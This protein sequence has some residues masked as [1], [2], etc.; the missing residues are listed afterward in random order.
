MKNKLISSFLV[1][2]IG[3][4][5]QSQISLT[6]TTGTTTGS[7]TNISAA[8]AAINAGTHT[9][10][11]VINI[12]S[13]ITA[14]PFLPT[15]LRESGFGAASYNDVLIRPVGNRNVTGAF[16]LNSNRGMIE[17][18]GAKNVTIDGDDPATA[19]T[20]NLA[21]T[22]NP[23]SSNLTAAI[24]IGSFSTAAFAE[25]IIVRNCVINGPRTTTSS[26]TLNCG[27][28]V[29]NATLASLVTQGLSCKNIDILNNEIYRSHVGIFIVGPSTS[30]NEFSNIRIA[31]NIIGTSTTSSNQL[32]RA[33]IVM[34]G[35]ASSSAATAS[36]IVS[37][38]ISVGFAGATHTDE[39]IGID[40]QL[41]SAGTVISHNEITDI[42]NGNAAAL[43][44]AGIRVNGILNSGISIFNNIIKD[45]VGIRRLPALGGIANY[46]VYIGTGVT[47]LSF[48][49][50]T[51]GLITQNLGAL[52]TARNSSLYIANTS[53]FSLFRN[54]ILVNNN[55]SPNATVVSQNGTIA[56]TYPT[57][58]AMDRNCYF[59]PGGSSFSNSEASLTSWQLMNNR[60][61]TSFLENPP[62]VSLNN[63]RIATGGVTR[64]ES[65][66]LLSTLSND[67]D[68]NPRPGPVGSVNGG[69]TIRDIGAHEVD[70]KSYI[71]STISAI[72]IPNDIA[73]F[74][75]PRTITAVVSGGNAVETV[76]LNYRIGP[77]P[78]T[79][80]IMT[81]SSTLFSG[82]IPA[83]LPQNARVTFRIFTNNA[84]LDTVSSNFYSYNNISADSAMFPTVTLDPQ[85]ICSN[86]PVTMTYA[87]PPDPTGV[88]APP[89][90][91]DALNLS[92]L[93]TVTIAGMTNNTSIGSL[94]G[95]IGTATGTQ[96]AYS[97]FR[98]MATPKVTL[99]YAYPLTMTSVSNGLS[100][101]FFAAYV[102]WNGD[103]DFNDANE[104]VFN[105]I[106]ARTQ[107]PRTEIGQL[108]VVPSA[109]PGIT[110]VRVIVSNSPITGPFS[111]IST[112]EVEDY[113]IEIRR[114]PS[115]EWFVGPTSLG[116][117]NPTTYTVPTAPASFSLKITDSATCF[118]TS[119]TLATV[120][121]SAPALTVSISGSP[122]VCA[123][124]I[125]G[126]V[127]NVSGGC[128]PYTYAWSTGASTRSIN[129]TVV[130]AATIPYSVTVT[131]RNS[132]PGV[133]NFVIT[134]VNPTITALDT[135]VCNRGSVDLTA[136]VANASGD[137]AA[138]YNSFLDPSFS[139]LKLGRPFKTPVLDVT[140]T[141]FVAAYRATTNFIG[142]IN[143]TGFTTSSLIQPHT[144]FVFNTSE[145]IVI[146]SV[147]LYMAG[148][149]AEVNIALLDRFGSIIAQTGK[150]KVV[151]GASALVPS[152]VPLFFSIPTP[153]VGYRLAI[154]DT[155]G[156]T[157]L[158]RNTGVVYPISAG[159]PMVITGGY[160]SQ[161]PTGTTE[162]NCF[163]N[164]IINRNVCVGTKVPV[165]VKVTTPRVP[166][167][168]K[169]IQSVQVCPGSSATISIATDSFGD[170][171][172][173]FVNRRKVSL[174]FVSNFFGKNLPISSVLNR[175]SARSTVTIP[176]VR[177]RDTGLYF[178]RVIPT[179]VCTRDTFS[180]EIRLSYY[181]EVVFTD[182]LKTENVCL[183]RGKQ[184]SVKT[185]FGSEYNWYRNGALVKNDTPSV[186]GARSYY[187]IDSAVY[188]DSG[189][190][191]VIA[192]HP[193]SC[194]PTISN[195]DT[196]NVFVRDT[197]GITLDPID[198]VICVG[199]KYT[200]RSRASNFTDL[201]WYK[202]GSPIFGANQDTLVLFRPLLADSGRYQLK[203][204]SYPG[205]PDSFSKKASIK[206]NR[207][208][209]ING[210]YPDLKFCEN[211]KL[212]L[213]SNYEMSPGITWYKNNVATTNILD[214]LVIPFASLSDAG[215]YYYVAQPFDKCP[216][217]S[218]DT[219][220]V[221]V[222]AKPGILNTTVPNSAMCS[223]V[224]LTKAFSTTNANFYQWYKN[225][226]PL[227]SE[228][229]SIFS[230]ESVS[231]NDTGFYNL[232]VISD[233]ICPEAISPSFRVTV[234][235]R[236]VITKHPEGDTLC[237]GDNITLS[238]S[239]QNSSGFQ[240][241]KNGVF[242]TN[243]TNPTL[244]LTNISGVNIG[245]Y[246]AIV[247]GIAPCPDLET[248]TAS[249]D[250]RSGASN[251]YL[252]TASSYSLRE[253][254]RDEDGW[255]YYV[256]PS[257]PNKF[258]FG[259][260]K[261]GNTT[262]VGKA[263][264][265]L[266]PSVF[267]HIAN[268]INQYSGSIL[269]SRYWN[270][271]VESGSF[272]EPVDVKF[273]YDQNELTSLN[274]RR[275]EIKRVQ[276]SD[277]I[278]EDE[279]ERWFKTDSTEMTPDR[280]AQIYGSY[281]GFKFL[282]LKDYE[283]DEENGVKYIIF[284]DVTNIG[285]G[286]AFY[287]FNGKTKSIG[288]VLNQNGAL[289]SAIYPNPNAGQFE[290]Q[291]YVQKIAP[292]VAEVY[293]S[294][295][296]K[297]YSEQI[298]VS[299]NEMKISMTLPEMAS[300]IYQL[301]LT[302]GEHSTSLKFRIDK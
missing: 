194:L 149:N 50:N 277:V 274:S 278:F 28:V 78:W 7:Y 151:L 232:R 9:G 91:L 271:A 241:K 153:G 127:A 138:W 251:A 192:K 135:F 296:Q 267:Q 288:A 253:Q 263:D 164:I 93:G 65:N 46:G 222:F 18:F 22:V 175:D 189:F 294:L 290:L 122:S 262:L 59:Y 190:Y 248:D 289:S 128:P 92:D 99:G 83:A 213:N 169:D 237:A 55:V 198:T 44:L 103:G 299:K 226:V 301:M 117:A 70:G 81:G 275:D 134:P 236:A 111:T 158:T 14:E 229:D 56:A 243:K 57:G 108:Y 156:I 5:V 143:P 179:K 238:V 142:R 170:A 144:G 203:A 265:V 10:S 195:I 133:A 17:L 16:G 252:A 264:V 47:G 155:G 171:F 146:R 234:Q 202:D 15:S 219:F 75:G 225:G 184:L 106:Q 41:N 82:T 230:I 191:Y 273:Y 281:F 206:I 27:I 42:I 84:L 269:M 74:S 113:T 38:K 61:L 270:Y 239:A 246:T 276:G 302:Q 220:K 227:Q 284:R 197:P 176:S 131:D 30:G 279:T 145:P 286:T 98:N 100:R 256:D 233:P 118:R 23:A 147:D 250:I 257:Q 231:F 32:G 199:T 162:Y 285:G 19:G 110:N 90:V 218:S 255:T 196:V 43:Q 188:Q 54:N 115:I 215:D 80:I 48:F 283:K 137:S 96:G 193:F 282:Q 2:L 37:N 165:E 116:T 260:N 139:F 88:T 261:K 114:H 21:F 183:K 69:G 217:V 35:V 242:E 94:T 268:D 76:N 126:M 150:V 205:C 95:S 73:C 13:D 187:E 200:I 212:R 166:A 228:I 24:R 8:F 66:A 102:D 72:T 49:H 85:Q 45:V 152:R 160:N 272:D 63:L 87:Y 52:T 280:I 300:G 89:T 161:N 31:N 104:A 112:G 25:S 62:F 29:S 136:T 178:V 221:R 119:A 86:T 34:S 40:I 235:Q 214:T 186:L 157:T 291:C 140:T 266:R 180:R 292:M 177:D 298:K 159:Q 201:Q 173:W 120:T 244:P 224:K 26:I 249:I 33:G 67:I 293:N 20:R 64:V 247:R 121:A 3:F 174:S 216:S 124:T 53:S 148:A 254:C 129:V 141:F 71:P 172:D 105:T 79:N 123:N 109:R 295:G 39:S 12:T 297:V 182:S 101:D 223:G 168:T 185:N 204:S 107:G 210:F 51:V 36:T 240:W 208:P 258:L 181:P 11:I 97:N 209:L 259:V 4:E 6:A 1:L 167:I 211:T 154:I 130:G 245:K 60:D 125:A 77:G 68:L 163:Y 207:G 58:N 287:K 132:L